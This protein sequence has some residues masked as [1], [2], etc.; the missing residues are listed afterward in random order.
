MTI[1]S[2][3]VPEIP[4]G[5]A[6]ESSSPFQFRTDQSLSCRQPVTLE[7]V[8]GV[9]NEGVF[10]VVYEVTAG[11]G[12]DCEHPTGTCE[13]CFVVS[14]HITTNSPTLLRSHNFVGA[15]SLGFPPKRCPET[16][17]YADTVAVPYLTHTFT[18]STTNEL[19]LTAQLRSHCPDAPTNALGVVAYVATNDY[20]SPCVNYLGDTGADGTQPFSFRVPPLTNFLILVSARATNVVCGD[21]TFELF[22]LPCPP[23]ALRIAKDTVP[24]KVVL[25]WST[26]EP[27]WHLQTTNTL[28]A[29]GPTPYGNVNLPPVI[30]DGQYTVTNASTELRQFFR[31]AR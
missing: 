6:L 3:A 1:A 14:G 20:H 26:A 28:Q 10:A 4:R 2:A 21:Y 5:F 17:V 27:G 11:E 24:N 16:N 31:L 25:R 30:A 19:Y 15:P 23:P 18:N 29:T 12:P 9:K 22:G 8:I 13:S 7:L